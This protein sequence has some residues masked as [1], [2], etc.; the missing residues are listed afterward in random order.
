MKI[1][2]ECTTEDLLKVLTPNQVKELL[3]I[4]PTIDPPVIHF[5]ELTAP[6]LGEVLRPLQSP[7]YEL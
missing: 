5:T 4:E 2:I 7:N 1:I 3:G 6:R